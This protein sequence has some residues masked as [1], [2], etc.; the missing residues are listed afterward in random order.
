M[1]G[2][3]LSLAPIAIFVVFRLVPP[4]GADEPEGVDLIGVVTKV[5]VLVAAA[6]C[7]VLW[8]LAQAGRADR[9]ESGSGALAPASR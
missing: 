9:T 4:P 7:L 5:T 1:G 2:A 8:R 6:A 3:A